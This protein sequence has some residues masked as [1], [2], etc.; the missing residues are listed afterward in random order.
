MLL[1]NKFLLSFFFMTWQGIHS[2][3]VMSYNIYAMY[4]LFFSWLQRL[5]Q[6]ADIGLK[7]YSNLLQGNT[8]LHTNDILSCDSS[9]KPEGLIR[10][11]PK[12]TTPAHRWNHEIYYYD[13]P[14]HHTISP[15]RWKDIMKHDFDNH[16]IAI[17]ERSLWVLQ[18]A[19][20]SFM[21]YHLDLHRY[22]YLYTSLLL[23]PLFQESHYD[24]FKK[25]QIWIQ[26]KEGTVIFAFSFSPEEMDLYKNL[27]DLNLSWMK[28]QRS[29]ISWLSRIVHS[30]ESIQSD[31]EKVRLFGSDEK[32]ETDNQESSYRTTLYEIINFMSMIE[33]FAPENYLN[34]ERKLL[35]E[36]HQWVKE[37]LRK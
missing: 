9:K 26:R 12:R 6:Q 15:D 17:W 20:K 37:A 28:K 21:K 10:P 1:I 8:Q 36:T 16:I 29:I 31:L 7:I 2:E 4:T 19:R 34:F 23:N 14:G 27:N 35:E 11:F 3:Y 33:W 18:E 24:Q 25:K 13:F 5:Y 22:I 30:V 32:L